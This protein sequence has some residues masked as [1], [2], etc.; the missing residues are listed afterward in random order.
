[1]NDLEATAAAF[2]G[3]GHVWNRKGSDR[4]HRGDELRFV[5]QLAEAEKEY[6]RA[7]RAF[8]A[9]VVVY[10]VALDLYRRSDT[11]PRQI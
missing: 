2:E 6:R 8:G 3:H 9:A 11:H 4:M 1:M 5:G 7:A 10:D